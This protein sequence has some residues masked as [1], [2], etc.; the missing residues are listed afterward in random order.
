[1]K[2]LTD[3]LIKNPELYEQLISS[4]S[5]KV[6][7]NG[8]TV[9]EGILENFE[10]PEETE[11]DNTIVCEFDV[12]DKHAMFLLTEN[13]NIAKVKEL[14]EGRSFEKIYNDAQLF[15]KTM[16]L[17]NSLP[18]YNITNESNTSEQNLEGIRKFGT[19]FQKIYENYYV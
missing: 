4:I 5:C 1:M 2:A 19:N 14:F 18:L 16:T 15:N 9:Y 17:A 7:N 10:L 3:I 11:I 13:K 8:I 6:T 12:N